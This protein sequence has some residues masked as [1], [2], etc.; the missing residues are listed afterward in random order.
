MRKFNQQFSKQ[1]EYSFVRSNYENMMVAAT[2]GSIRKILFGDRM[3]RMRRDS[4]GL[5]IKEWFTYDFHPKRFEGM[6]SSKGRQFA[7]KGRGSDPTMSNFIGCHKWMVP[8]SDAW[9]AFGWLFLLGIWCH[10]IKFGSH[11][12]FH[13]GFQAKN[14][15][16]QLT[17][18][19]LWYGQKGQSAAPS[20]LLRNE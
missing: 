3:H 6:W 4:W 16:S 19:G 12:D 14:F 18:P 2:A 10:R 15:P 9:M 20:N 13:A 8:N 5:W 17:P 7:G 11:A 1:D